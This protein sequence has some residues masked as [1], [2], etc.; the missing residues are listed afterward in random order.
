MGQKW[1]SRKL[2]VFVILVLVVLFAPLTQAEPD[3]LK[4]I[5]GLGGVYLAGQSAVDATG[6]GTGRAPD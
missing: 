6:N 2:A 5:L 4:W 1:N 3:L